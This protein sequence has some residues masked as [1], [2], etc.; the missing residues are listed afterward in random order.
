MSN[1]ALQEL[2]NNNNPFSEYTVRTQDIW[3]KEFLDEPYLNCHASDM[4][5]R[6]VEQLESHKL[7]VIGITLRAEKGVGKSHIVSRIRHR[8]QESGSALF[9]Y[10]GNYGNLNDMRS[11]F[12]KNLAV[13]LK[14]TGSKNV[15]QWQ[16]LAA[17]LVNDAYK[18]NYHPCELISRFAKKI[19]ANHKF[20]EQLTD[21]ICTIKPD[22]NNPS[23]IQAIL[24][25]LSSP[26]DA[27]YAIKWLAGNNLPQSKCDRLGLPNSDGEDNS[28]KSFDNT[29]EILSLI[30]QYKSVVICFDQLEGVEISDAGFTKAQVVANFGMDL[31]NNIHRGVLL[32]TVYR[33]IWAEQIKAL[34][35]A[36]AVVDRI[37]QEV[38]D[39]H[40]LNSDSAVALV[41]RRLTS[42]YDKYQVTPPHELYPFDELILREKGKQKASARDVLQWCQKNW[43][44]LP[45]IDPV[46]LVQNA[47]EKELSSLKPEEFMDDRNK[48]SQALSFGFDSLVGKTLAGV[49]VNSIDRNVIPKAA[50]KNH[51][52]L[53]I[54]CTENDRDV[55]IGVAIV[56]YSTGNGIQA[57]L[58]RLVKYQ[59]FDLTRGCLLRSKAITPSAKKA[60]IL[61]NQLLNELGGEWPPMKI[62]D[63]KPL[64]AIRSV[65]DAR[66]DYDLAEADIL[67]FIEG[68]GLAYQNLLL[69]DILSDPSGQV[70]DDLVN[71]DE[72]FVINPES[73]D[74]VDRSLDSEGLD[75]VASI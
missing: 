73:A 3:G 29:C 63:L 7:N 56:Q 51:L 72:D 75:L 34:P 40:F 38:I 43:N 16:E 41:K 33:D 55:K 11:E 49:T 60:H 42:F 61:V 30:S 67:K 25:T 21:K 17:A 58:S 44:S 74:L 10:M 13:S 70:P 28:I 62:E 45:E 31:Y 65:F 4:V 20:V 50:N 18:K 9:V 15:T 46:N 12:L 59:E 57:A 39:L 2:I 54:L 52:D 6:Y 32:T 66:E 53:R 27:S 26:V 47:Y 1:D 71:E 68:T 24:W 8:L 64:I 22:L 5:F 48:I 14:Q 36:E 19:Q 23:I 37:G 35:C 69:L